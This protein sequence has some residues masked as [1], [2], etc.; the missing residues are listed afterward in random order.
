MKYSFI[1][2]E[3]SNNINNIKGYKEISDILKEFI[4]ID[5]GKIIN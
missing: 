1:R 3:S 2:I 4:E 5:Y